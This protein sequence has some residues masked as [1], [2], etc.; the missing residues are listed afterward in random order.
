[1]KLALFGASGLADE[2]AHLGMELGCSEVVLL[3][4]SGSRPP[5]RAFPTAPED[6]AGALAAAGYRFAIAIGD[7]QIRRKLHQTYPELPY[8][9]LV[10][11]AATLPAAIRAMLPER[12]GTIV[13]AG[14]RFTSSIAIGRFGIYNPN[15][16]VSHDC[17][18]GDYTTIGPGANLCGNVRL[19]SGVYVGAGAIIL[20]GHPVLGKLTLGEDAVIGAGAVVTR[21][22]SA[23]STVKGNPAR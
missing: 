9:S 17:E 22:V 3:H 11:P 1:M 10:H 23:R 5:A 12:S 7:P 14:V 6:E 4:P 16:T 13:M 21:S 20:P 18:I 15:C 19:K 2:T 8:T